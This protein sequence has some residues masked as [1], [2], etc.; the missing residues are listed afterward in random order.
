MT[1]HT[2]LALW[3][4]GVVASFLSMCIQGKLDGSIAIFHCIVFALAWPLHCFGLFVGL[5]LLRQTRQA[6]RKIVAENIIKAY[7]AEDAEI[8][9][10]EREP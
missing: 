7:D 9:K 6:Y 2:L 1:G 4:G 8:E 3:L 10:E 5:S